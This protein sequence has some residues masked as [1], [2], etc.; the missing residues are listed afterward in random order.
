MYGI[1]A[2]VLQIMQGFDKGGDTGRSWAINGR[3]LT[4]R[5]TGVQRHAY[6]IV[7]AMDAILS[8]GGDFAG[9]RCV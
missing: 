2:N 1:A 3:F 8:P 5:I 6:E 9:R 4:Q 7:S